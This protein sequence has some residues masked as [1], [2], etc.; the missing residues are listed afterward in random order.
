MPT[1]T[2]TNTANQYNPGG[3]NTYNAF[4]PQ[5][6][7][8]LMQMAQNPLGSNYF[9]NQLA[10]QQ[11]A[12]HQI[13]Q[14]GQSNAL[15]NLRAGGGILSNSGGFTSA[16]INRNNLQGSALQ[17]NAF[18]SAINTALQN[19]NMALMSMQA[20]QPL[21]T[22]QNTSQQTSGTGTW[23]PQVAGMAMN[24]LSPGLGSMMGG[25]GF[26][27]GYQQQG[28]GGSGGSSTY[29]GPPASGNMNPSNYGPNPWLYGNPPSSG[30]Y[31]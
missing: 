5:L 17:S 13:S 25:N 19:R 27:A 18:N 1:T 29:S 15:Q 12:A 7:S 23:L 11:S 6:M 22:G 9:H 28:G 24:M 3:L 10:Q 14:R 30:G 4:Q 20:Y 21:Q 31:V 8:S 2:Q 16:L 26:S